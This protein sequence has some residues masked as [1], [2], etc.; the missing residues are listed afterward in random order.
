MTSLWLVR[1]GQT[2]WNFAGRWQ[3]QSSHAPGLNEVGRTQALS[4]RDQLKSVQ[5]S[6]IYSS[7][8]LRS[9]QTAELIANP[10][11]LRVKLEPRLREMKLGRWE[12]MLSKEIEPDF[13]RSG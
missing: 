13:T 1:H 9:R 3:G 5:L 7:D 8:L 11:G 10:L 12:G 6:S 2:D 4:L